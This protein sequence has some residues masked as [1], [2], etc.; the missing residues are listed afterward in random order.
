P[1]MSLLRLE[2]LR[3]LEGRMKQ[4]ASRRIG[5]EHNKN[6]PAGYT[7]LAQLVIHDMVE[8]TQRFAAIQG[9]PRQSRRSGRVE[10]LLL[11]SI[12]GGGPTTDPLY[13]Q[14]PA[15]PVD[16]RRAFRLD[17]IRAADSD[18]VSAPDAVDTAR[19]LPRG[20]CPFAGRPRRRRDGGQNDALVSDVRNDDNVIVSQLTVLF[21]LLH[22]QVLAKLDSNPKD[23]A[24][25]VPKTWSDRHAERR[26]RERFE[27]ARRIVTLTFRRIVFGDLLPRLLD[28]DVLRTF[29]DRDFAP[30]DLVDGPIQ[31]AFS[32]IAG[33][34]GHAMI[35]QTYTINKRLNASDG[36]TTVVDI[37]RH[38][39]TF[40]PE[41]MPLS[42]DWVVNWS[43]LFPIGENKH[44]N[45][46]VIGPSFATSIAGGSIGKVEIEHPCSPDTLI[47]GGLPLRDFV[48]GEEPGVPG[49]NAVKST[50]PAAAAA[51]PLFRDGDLD[52]ERIAAFLGKVAGK[53]ATFRDEIQR[54]PPLLLL[55]LLEAIRLEPPGEWRGGERLGPL[56]ST[57]WA[58]AVFRA[59]ARSA[60]AI[61]GDEA[62]LHA[63][64][65][66]FDGEIPA[67]MPNLIRTVARG[68]G[69]DARH[70][71]I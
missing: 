40:R 39:S 35:R 36:F 51:S 6:I 62:L 41:K 2:A 59:R 37:V 64:E 29:A 69:W 22:N 9:A 34:I 33:R 28:P 65:L 53:E 67:D 26:M 21:M 70:D 14:S 50:Y 30:A 27:L 38:N 63:A 60:D 43:F 7:Y 3:W 23:Y 11:E 12:Y 20:G 17:R 25:V 71:F 57:I 13:Y 61:E 31:S 15:R 18:N 32:H 16:D 46:R 55:L 58:D 24:L 42:D 44:L 68:E 8:T 19:D 1:Q 47:Y 5:P 4:A 48:R 45:S 52:T 10:Q 56:A 49:I 54:D 66:V